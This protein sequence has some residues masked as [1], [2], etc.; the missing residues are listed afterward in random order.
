MTSSVLSASPTHCGTGTAPVSQRVTVTRWTPRY[1]ASRAC[2]SPA[3]V[4]RVRSVSG[5]TAVTGFPLGK[6]DRVAVGEMFRI[7]R[8]A[9]SAIADATG[10]APRGVAYGGQTDVS[11]FGSYGMEGLG[12]V[13][14]L[15]C[16]APL[17]ALHPSGDHEDGLAEFAEREGGFHVRNRTC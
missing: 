11:E 2:E 7:D 12:Y 15:G 10:R 3:S 9:G 17:L 1:A 6:G 16:D 5:V 14:L 13:V 8:C 4:R